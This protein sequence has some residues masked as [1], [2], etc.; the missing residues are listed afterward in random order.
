MQDNR[1]SALVLKGQQML[2]N[3]M[4]G[5]Q[6]GSLVGA[7]LHGRQ[8]AEHNVVCLGGQLVLDDGLGAAQHVLAQHLLQIPLPL[9]SLQTR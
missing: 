5:A 8:A 3:N 9:L 2:S 4:E 1:I 6:A 7:L